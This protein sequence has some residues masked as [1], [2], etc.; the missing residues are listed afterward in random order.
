MARQTLR[1]LY[2]LDSIMAGDKERSWLGACL[3]TRRVWRWGGVL[4]HA[5][6]QH[7]HRA[8]L[9]LRGGVL[10]VVVFLLPVVLHVRFDGSRGSGTKSELGPVRRRP[11][12]FGRHA[13]PLDGGPLLPVLLRRRRRAENLGEQHP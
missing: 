8:Q 11:L 3:R 5:L 4:E 9:L 10:L 13:A 1:S 7:G 6:L 2:E 12:L